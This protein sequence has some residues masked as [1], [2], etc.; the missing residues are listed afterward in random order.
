MKLYLTT[1][2]L[3]LILLYLADTT[4]TWRPFSITFGQ[5]WVVLGMILI[6]C[7]CICLKCQWYTDGLKKGAEIKKE[8]L[9][10]VLKE[11]IKE[12]I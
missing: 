8:A 12:K 4:I 11:K 2:A 6:M 7:G 3:T 9:Q 1:L 10:E 5:G